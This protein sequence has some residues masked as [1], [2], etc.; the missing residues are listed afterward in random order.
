MPDRDS[1]QPEDVKLIARLSPQAYA[2]GFKEDG[3]I[4]VCLRRGTEAIILDL[5]F[6][7]AGDIAE[8]I[9]D[10]MLQAAEEARLAANPPDPK[11]LS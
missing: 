3:T 1:I 2:V 4:G 10:A 9:L 7:L 5:D 8:A 6:E 11:D